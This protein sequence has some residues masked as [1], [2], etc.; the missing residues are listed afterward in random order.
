MDKLI[1]KKRINAGKGIYNGRKVVCFFD[2]EIRGSEKE[3][4]LSIMADVKAETG[5]IITCGQCIDLVANIV[6][7]EKNK[8]IE[9]IWKRWH[10]NDLH[11]GCIH[12]RE[13]EKEPYEKHKGC[14]CD[15]CNYTYGTSW[16]YEKLPDEII[17]EVTNW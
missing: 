3:P 4:V 7:T 8:R 10:L 1:F 17:E 6:P 5:G 9:A 16:I 15:I 13:F 14:H 11:A 12:Q 2:I